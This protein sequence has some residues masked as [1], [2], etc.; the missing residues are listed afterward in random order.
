[1]KITR[2]TAKE[3]RDYKKKHAVKLQAAYDDAQPVVLEN[4]D[5][6]PVVRIGRG[7]ASFKKYINKKGRPKV[8]DK[9]ISVSLRLPE[10]AI[11]SLRS[12]TGRSW[13]SY[14][15][16]YIIKGLN[17]GDFEKYHHS[18]KKRPLP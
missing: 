17:N 2:M 10:S 18:Y 5:N 12:I 15:R 6:Q 16:D 13:R 11:K 14:A 8:D 4:D 9:Q 1:M 7:F 3:M